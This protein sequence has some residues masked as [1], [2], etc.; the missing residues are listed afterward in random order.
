M[1]EFKVII[2]Q[3]ENPPKQSPW[4]ENKKEFLEYLSE[5]ID[6]ISDEEL[7]GITRIIVFTRLK[8]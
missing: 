1:K 3:K 5:I 6:T 2:H 7:T 8:D 4:V